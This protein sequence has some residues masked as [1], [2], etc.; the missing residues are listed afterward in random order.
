MTLALFLLGAA[1]GMWTC[2]SAYRLGLKRGYQQ[3][4]NA[5]KQ[6][7]DYTG[8]GDYLQKS[9]ERGRSNAR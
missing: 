1:V 4:F 8:W 2:C 7:N 5:C 6:S 3:G 9:V